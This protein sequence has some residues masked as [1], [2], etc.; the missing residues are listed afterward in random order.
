MQGVQGGLRLIVQQ[1][2]RL[3]VLLLIFISIS[4]IS[5]GGGSGSSVPPPPPPPTNILK[6]ASYANTTCAINAVNAETQGELTCWGQIPDIAVTDALS[7]TTTRSYRVVAKPELM[8]S[9][10]NWVD[11]AVGRDHI[12]GIKGVAGNNSLHCMGWNNVGQLGLALIDNK[13]TSYTR[14][15]FTPSMVLVNDTS[16]WIS[17]SA[18]L[19]HTCGIYNA[20]TLKCWG[21]NRF[22][23]LAQNVP[24]TQPGA[25]L[26]LNVFTEIEKVNSVLKSATAVDGGSWDKV[27]TNDFH[28]CGIK[29]DNSLWC[30]GRNN[31][32]QLGFASTP[33]ISFMQFVTQVSP[34]LTVD[35][36]Q[37]L[38]FDP[39]TDV[40]IDVSVGAAQSCAISAKRDAPAKQGKLWCWGNNSFRELGLPLS[41]AEVSNKDLPSLNPIGSASDWVKVVAGRAQTCAINNIGETFCFGYDAPVQF[42]G[43][44]YQVTAVGGQNSDWQSITLG[45]NHACGIKLVNSENK[46]FCWGQ[47]QYSQLGTGFSYNSLI[48]NLVVADSIPVD[49]PYVW[50]QLDTGSTHSCAIKNDDTLWCWGRSYSGQL[51]LGNVLPNTTLQQVQPNTKWLEVKSN[52]RTT[53]A[54]KVDNTLWCWGFNQR[55]QQGNG[56][57]INSFSPV[58]TK[59]AVSENNWT[60]LF[61]GDFFSCAQQGD[62]TVWCWGSN[63]FGQIAQ[64]PNT[65]PAITFIAEKTPISPTI[66]WIAG[67]V[68]TGSRAAC[69]ISIDQNLYCWGDNSFDRIDN[70]NTGKVVVS[71][72]KLIPPPANE[73]VWI[74]AHIGG[75]PLVEQLSGGKGPVVQQTNGS[76]ICALSGQVIDST[77]GTLWCWGD[78]AF[79]A[80]GATTPNRTIPVTAPIKVSTD[81][82]S[83]TQWRQVSVNDNNVCAIKNDGT[84][85]CWGGSNSQ[86][87]LGIGS[88]IRAVI[89]TQEATKSTDWVAVKTGGHHTCGL[90]SQNGKT[91]Y[92]LWC[93]GGT[94]YERQLG[95]N[96]LVDLTPKRIQ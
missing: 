59:G 81:S 45:F 70:I 75:N 24:D 18:A 3:N 64:A 12:C 95:D 47:Q 53:C 67:K 48:P 82:N 17:L 65:P 32:K 73:E 62:Q 89:P 88:T 76:F 33:E 52:F 10:A 1:Q 86:G 21:A 20:K 72:P 28:T 66:S 23:V 83:V 61:V 63:S 85:W 15:K 26:R 79:A 29:L 80:L 4:F 13:F 9:D 7:G 94:S 16:S 38:L 71:T 41:A 44:G 37:Q 43:F 8:S 35:S 31:V 87:E 36:N 74:S 11:V 5:C 34:P 30:W 56:S 27:S 60:G 39:L 57:R 78:N 2:N 25:V 19:D 92:S 40:W 6:T 58:K 90:Q 69:A 50:K 46:L 68:F 84:L 49:D 96:R 51:G 91:N 22:G 77:E 14:D 42:S 93:W 55:A 54:R